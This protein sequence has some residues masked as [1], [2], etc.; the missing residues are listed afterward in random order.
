MDS[1]QQLLLTFIAAV[2]GQQLTAAQISQPAACA[3]AC[4]CAIRL[5]KRTEPYTAE[6]AAARQ[7][8]ASNRDDFNALILAAIA[9]KGSAGR[10]HLPVTGTAAKLIQ[11]CDTA[12]ESDARDHKK[13]LEVTSPARALLT[14]L[15]VI[16]KSAGVT[17]M[18]W[19]GGG[20]FSQA[21]AT[22][23]TFGKID[24]NS[25]CDDETTEQSKSFSRT[26]EANEK[27]IPDVLNHVILENT[28]DQDGAGG[29]CGPNSIG[30]SAFIKYGL[31]LETNKGSPTNVFA[32]AANTPE[33]VAVG[34]F[35]LATA[36]IDEANTQLK[37]RRTD[38]MLSACNK[39]LRDFSNFRNDPT[40]KVLVLKA[41]TLKE[42][43]EAVTG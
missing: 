11:A 31:N 37:D 36:A 39:K 18:T 19:A 2:V 29:T 41:L 14:A 32:T 27:D 26:T 10:K 34:V 30:N 5:E 23:K 1:R 38:T 35:K 3:T 9:S 12:L 21:S 6:A 4:G 20:Q 22:H 25:K 15:H 8:A 43:A 40:F 28:C 24:P 17:H 7:N 16:S 13:L 42:K 33:A